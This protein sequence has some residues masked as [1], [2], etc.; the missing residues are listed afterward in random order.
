MHSFH[1]SPPRAWAILAALLVIGSAALVGCDIRSPTPTPSLSLEPLEAT[2]W[3][4]G[5]TV[6]LYGL[7]IDPGL[8]AGLPEV[9]GGLPLM[10]SAPLEVVALDDRDQH[11]R[12]EAFAAAQAG[13]AT[14]ADWISV[15]VGLV[16]ADDQTEAFYSSWRSQ[17]F[18]GA[19]SQADGVAA[20]QQEVI[21]DWDVYVARCNGGAY[22][23]TLW[24]QEGKLLS[25]IELGT[26]HLGRELINSLN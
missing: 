4:P 9:V 24:L 25:I 1:T 17:F 12:F 11:V 3:G 18:E 22:A 19:C 14:A 20:T 16:R 26:R 13:S 15:Y 6:G 8:L 23:Y 7:R 10:E 2:P 5:G 21:N